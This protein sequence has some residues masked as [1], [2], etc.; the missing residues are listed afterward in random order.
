[1]VCVFVI[2]YDAEASFEPVNITGPDTSLF[3]FA[4]LPD[5]SALV[6]AALSW[7]SWIFYTQAPGEDKNVLFTANEVDPELEGLGPGLVL[8][9]WYEGGD[10][11]QIQTFVFYPTDFDLTKRYPLAFIVHGGLQL[12]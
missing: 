6:S 5:G 2:P 4:V 9:F 1:M 8:N 10:G 11:N 7:T 12:S 3:D